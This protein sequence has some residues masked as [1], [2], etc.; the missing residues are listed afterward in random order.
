[1]MA[2]SNMPVEK[3]EALA[4][5]LSKVTFQT[6]PKM[7]SYLLF[8]GLGDFVRK[9]IKIG[10]VEVG[11]IT[12]RGD[13]D[14]AE[15]ALD[16]ASKILPY[17]D[18]YFGVPYPLPKLDLIAAPMSGGFGAMENWGAVLYAEDAMLR[19]PKFSTERGRQGV[20]NVIAHE[21]AHQW[22]GNLVTMAWWDDLWLNEGFA[23]WMA[24]KASDHF[25]PEWNV[26]AQQESGKQA[27]I[28]VDSLSSHHPI[29]M[30]VYSAAAA[31]ESFDRITYQKG[32]AVIRM[33]ESYAGADTFRAGLQAYMKKY[34]YSNAVTAQFWKEHELAGSKKM[35]AI[36]DAFT[37]EPGVPLLAVK[38]VTCVNGKSVLDLSID[39]FSMESINTKRPDW[40]LPVAIKIADQPGITKIVVKGAAKVTA[41]GCGPAIVNA[42]QD[43]YLIAVYAPAAFEMVASAYPKLSLTDQIGILANVRMASSAGLQPVTNSLDLIQVT[44]LGADPLVWIASLR[45]FQ[46]L[47][48]T[49]GGDDPRQAKFRAYAR[50]VVEPVLA[51]IGWDKRPE[52]SAN[53]IQL[54]QQLL[55]LLGRFGS[56]EIIA[57]ARRRFDAMLVDHESLKGDL[58][59][60]VMQIVAFNA[61]ASAFDKFTALA[62]AAPTELERQQILTNLAQVKDPALAAKA[63]DYF[64]SAAVPLPLAPRLLDIGASEHPEATFAFAKQHWGDIKGRLDA[65]ESLKYLP[66]LASASYNPATIA[67]M[68]KF[69]KEN[70]PPEAGKA[71]DRAEGTIM[72]N[73]KNRARNVPEIDKWLDRVG[74]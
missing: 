31:T 55:L 21:T 8:Y 57:E 69:V 10:K 71:A 18:D 61:D 60:T 70:L 56:P 48:R 26:W 50:K 5:G 35:T 23:T 15:F 22:F 44:P 24:A 34:A 73:A 11:V 62:Q 13:L 40:S 49:I 46:A 65:L 20:F 43:S 63:R 53:T 42:G 67:D 1:M 74:N 6:S 2:V 58:R 12:K 28:S 52:D 41:P 29:V 39:R 19:D 17:Y 14:K 38:S 68:K 27:A 54:R 33:L 66:D 64:L 9:A 16:A 32:Q 37:H 51:P 4:D 25:H 59:D 45:N 47:D 30:P 36:A 7:S 72:V 3:T